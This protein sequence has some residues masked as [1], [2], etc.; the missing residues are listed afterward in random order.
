[1]VQ[2]IRISSLVQDVAHIACLQ[3]IVIWILDSELTDHRF[4][5][6]ESVA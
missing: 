6:F 1:M 3:I 2:F 4:P 5:V